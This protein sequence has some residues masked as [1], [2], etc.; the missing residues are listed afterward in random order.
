MPKVSRIVP[1]LRALLFLAVAAVILNA[2]SLAGAFVT[3]NINGLTFSY[4]NLV[5]MKDIPADEVDAAFFG[6][7]T[8]Q[9]GISPMTL[10]GEH[11]IRA[12]VLASSTQSLFSNYLVMQEFLRTHSVRVILLDVSFLHIQ[13]GQVDFRLVA[14]CLPFSFNKL[15]AVKNA[16]KSGNPYSRFSLILPIVTHHSRWKWLGR[17]GLLPFGRKEHQNYYYGGNMQNRYMQLPEI[18][19]WRSFSG[20]TDTT[21]QVRKPDAYQYEYFLKI[22]RLCQEKNI[23]L[24]LLRTPTMGTWTAEMHNS[25]QEIASAEK[26]PFIDFHTRNA[27]S[28]SEYNFAMNNY[29]RNHPNR[30]GAEKISLYLGRYLRDNFELPDRR[31]D[32]KYAY[33]YDDLERYTREMFFENFEP[34]TGLTRYL[35]MLASTAVNK[36]TV[37][38][39]VKGDCQAKMSNGVREKMQ[40]LGFVS[41]AVFKDPGYSFIG[42]WQNGKVLHEIQSPTKALTYRAVLPDGTKYYVKSAGLKS[43]NASSIVINGAQYS[44]NLPGFNVVVYDHVSGRVIDRKAWETAH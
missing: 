34:E 31:N 42:V 16:G 25:A 8:V 21:E 32:P 38:F 9:T 14:D 40:E 44:G 28:D 26:L 7:S 12:Q 27:F 1:Y 24:I 11:G 5:D 20:W 15:V 18:A 17:P 37:I 41:E 43:G 29:D 39:S 22:V 2:L 6:A 10:F 36:Y 19:V 30:F 3:W 35:D 4:R 23:P 13:P 33:M